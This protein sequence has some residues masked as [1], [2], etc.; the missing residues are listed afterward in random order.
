MAK[1]ET[2]VDEALGTLPALVTAAE[3]E[4]VL[5]IKRRKINQLVSGGRLKSVRHSEGGS[6]LLITR[7]SIA[8]YLR[9]ISDVAA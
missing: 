8:T 5:R 9:S 1:Q 3:V 6:P 4:K 2:W 7:Q